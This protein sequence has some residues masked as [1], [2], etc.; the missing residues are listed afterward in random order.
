MTYDPCT[1]CGRLTFYPCKCEPFDVW[2]ADEDRD[3][4]KTVHAKEHEEAALAWAVR[5]DADSA[6]YGIAGRGD[7]VDVIV[8]RRS[9]GEE[10]RWSVTG[11]MQPTYLAKRGT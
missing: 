2:R 4:A 7:E 1:R 6:E 9:D 8:A 10:Q 11:E 5:D 3:E